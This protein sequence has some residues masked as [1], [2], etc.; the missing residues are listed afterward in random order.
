MGKTEFIDNPADLY[1]I[2]NSDDIDLSTLREVEI[3]EKLLQVHYKYNDKYVQNIRSSQ[4]FC[5]FFIKTS[6]LKILYIVNS[7][8]NS[9]FSLIHYNLFPFRKQLFYTLFIKTF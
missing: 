4:K 1:A 3:N 7:S 9:I 6:N 5:R 8:I 2:L